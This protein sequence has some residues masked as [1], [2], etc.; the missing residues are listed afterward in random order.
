MTHVPYK[1]IA[2]A[3]RDLVAGNIDFMFGA[4]QTA[5]P[6]VDGGQLRALAV[7][8]LE[9][10]KSMPEV[11]AVAEYPGLEGFQSDLWYGLLAP[12]GTDPAITASLAQKT[13]EAFSDPQVR[14][15]FEPFGNVLIGSTPAAFSAAIKREVIT[16]GEVLKTA[17]LI[18]DK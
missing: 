6:F 17:G 9:R 8:S 5:R 14:A 2:S 4:I 13:V 1:G 3:L 10:N 18:A 15:R 16:N 11:P 12:A 7:S